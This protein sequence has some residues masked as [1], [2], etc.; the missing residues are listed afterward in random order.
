MF[1]LIICAVVVGCAIAQI[2]RTRRI[3]LIYIL[4]NQNQFSGAGQREKS[5]AGADRRQ[6][7]PDSTAIL[8]DL[9][10]G[11]VVQYFHED[12]IV[13]GKLTYNDDGFVWMEYLLQLGER[14]AWLSV[15]EDD[16]L[17]TCLLDPVQ[18]LEISGDPPKQLT[19][20]G[21]EYRLKEASE[22]TMTRLTSTGQRTAEQ[23]QYYDYE[24]SNDLVLSIED[25]GGKREITAGRAISPR[26]LRIW[27]GDGQSVYR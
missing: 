10:I 11:D 20:Q 15:Q 23:C 27:P 6:Y 19:Y 26:S 22:A 14:T 12:W 16:A 8:F 2:R 4:S 9:R 18:D 7:A 1:L 21:N 17:E 13:E 24:G 3:A 25:W 5:D